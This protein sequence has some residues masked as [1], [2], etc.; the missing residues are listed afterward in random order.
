MRSVKVFMVMMIAILMLSLANSGSA[1]A[2]SSKE[3]GKQKKSILTGAAVGAVIGAV[4]GGPRTA[5][6]LA[7]VGG[8]AGYLADKQHRHR[9]AVKRANKINASRAYARRH[10]HPKARKR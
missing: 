6:K 8:G 5:L 2:T 9:T 10:R 4:I 7:V 1:Y 3:H